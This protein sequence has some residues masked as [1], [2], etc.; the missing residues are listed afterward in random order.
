MRVR[1]IREVL[2]FINPRVVYVALAHSEYI[3]S[4]LLP[5]RA[6]EIVTTSLFQIITLARYL[7][8]GHLKPN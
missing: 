5:S 1:G 4:V 6:F 3:G 7:L 8:V 2:D